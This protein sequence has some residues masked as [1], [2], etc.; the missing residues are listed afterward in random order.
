MR[1]VRV[2]DSHTSGT[3]IKLHMVPLSNY[4]FLKRGI[5]VPTSVCNLCSQGSGFALST[6]R[7]SCY[8][9]VRVAALWISVKP[10]E[11]HNKKPTNLFPSLTIKT[12]IPFSY[13]LYSAAVFS[14]MSLC[15]LLLC[16]S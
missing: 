7:N 16:C 1:F 2:R 6:N 11:D 4:L 9:K 5:F 10:L 13:T 12:C 3:S 8:S 15:L 14:P